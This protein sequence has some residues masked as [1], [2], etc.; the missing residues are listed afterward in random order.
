MRFID[1]HES[2]AVSIRERPTA[3]ASVF[4][5]AKAFLPLSISVRSKTIL[6]SCTYTSLAGLSS[7]TRPTASA[8]HRSI[9]SA[10]CKVKTPSLSRTIS[11]MPLSTR[12]PLRPSTFPAG[13]P[14]GVIAPLAVPSF[15]R[16]KG[17]G[18]D[19]TTGEPVLLFVPVEPDVKK[20]AYL[21]MAAAAVDAVDEDPEVVDDVDS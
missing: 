12:S 20:L 16:V 9:R 19:A 15:G 11:S 14:T 7:T 2:S 5:S 18:F 6:H 17:F 21:E 13:R 10:V 3:S 1:T 4:D 8:C